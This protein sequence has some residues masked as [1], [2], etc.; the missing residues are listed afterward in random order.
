MVHSEGNL[1]SVL[2]FFL[3]IPVALWGAYRW[4]PAKT[5]ALLLLLPLMFLPEQV[6]FKLP[7]LPVFTKQRVAVLWLLICVLLFH[8]DRLRSLRLG[9]WVWLAIISLLFGGVLTVFLNSDPVTYGAYYT[10][11]HVPYDA[12]HALIQKALGYVLP[13]MLGAA[14]FN[15][16]K[17]LR[18]LFRL[19]VGAGLAYS[20][21]QLVE[22]RLSP[23]LHIWVYGFFPHSFAQTMRGGGFRPVVFMQNG[24]E[25]AMFTVTALMAATALYKAKVPVL[26]LSAGWTVAYLAM[27][28]ILS[29]SVAAFLYAIALVPVMLL[30]APKTQFR[31]AML[32]AAIVLLYPTARGTGVIP[33]DDIQEWA[34]STYGEGKSASLMTRFVN[35]ERLLER[36]NERYFFGWG[37]YG[38][39]YARD[40]NS[41][42]VI[43]IR[44]G[45]WIITMGD[46][47][48]FGFFSKY[49][50]F[51]L[52]IFIAARRLKWVGRNSDRRLLA[53]LSL[54][55]GISAF[56][57]LPN[58]NFNYLVFVLSG[59]LLS[60]SAG[61]VRVGAEKARLRRELLARRRNTERAPEPA[62]AP[63]RVR[64][65]LG[66]QGFSS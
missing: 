19:L 4:P 47:G 64:A 9:K 63:A 26:R 1:L 65:D 38:R 35:E 16:P 33:V 17:D 34:G 13:L 21:L 48:R 20:L 32:M 22:I 60:C 12:V 29:K 6:Y 2:A 55:I 31:V 23:Q 27:I 5:A 58:G 42:R 49:L 3:W 50:L 40:P 51:L 43:G 53:A 66:R 44:D 24:L 18:V 59:A 36:G 15:G 52:P 8:R 37:W 28:L 57:L 61:V 62:P 46:W 10:P 11:P 30:F 45:D 39:A 54:I 41:G 7:G 56:D 25:V 14:M